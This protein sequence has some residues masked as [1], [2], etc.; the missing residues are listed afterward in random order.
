M[1]TGL[2]QGSALFMNSIGRGESKSF[3]FPQDFDPERVEGS[4]VP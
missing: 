2:A 1:G 4:K 3:E